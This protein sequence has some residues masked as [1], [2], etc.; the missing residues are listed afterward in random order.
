MDFGIRHM[1][2]FLAL[3]KHGTITRA[4]EFLGLSQPALSKSLAALEAQLGQQLFYRK[5]RNLLLSHHG[6]RL[7]PHANQLVEDCRS[8]QA[9]MADSRLELGGI[10]TLGATTSVAQTVLIPALASFLK[11]HSGLH[12]RLQVGNLRN[13]MA[14]LLD[15][16]VDL[17][18][19]AGH[20]QAPGLEFCNWMEDTMVTVCSPQAA[21]GLP[22]QVDARTLGRLPW[23]VREPGSGSRTLFD[24]AMEDRGVRATIVM[25]LGSN[26]A[27]RQ[28]A[29]HGLGLACLSRRALERDFREGS[30]LQVPGLELVRQF[31]MV[32]LRTRHQSPAVGALIQSLQGWQG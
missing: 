3:V 1:E 20:Y 26:D 8:L 29:V 10:L 13:T 6:R 21:F 2:H 5:A 15:H 11:S 24:N 19:V 18:L 4:A 22:K 28:A 31:S 7:L 23:L 27:I 12:V 16:E 25:E 9:A 30:L 14:A 17:A 32:S